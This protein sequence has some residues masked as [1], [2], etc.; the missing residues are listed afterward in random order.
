MIVK[1][2]N[3]DEFRNFSFINADWKPNQLLKREVLALTD[4]QIGNNST[5]QNQSHST[6]NSN[7]DDTLQAP[8]TSSSHSKDPLSSTFTSVSTTTTL[9][10]SMTSDSSPSMSPANPLI[11]SMNER[12]PEKIIQN[13]SI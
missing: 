11:N 1:A 9:I 10:S 12:K 13:T 6:V 8:L 2:I 3:Q 5:S 4:S 7:D